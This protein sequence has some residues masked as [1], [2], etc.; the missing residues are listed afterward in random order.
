M[1]EAVPAQLDQLRLRGGGPG[2][3]D[4]IRVR[5]LA[6]LLVRQ[7]DDCRFL[8]RWMPQEDAF[9]LQARDV[10]S[11]ADDHVLDA[12]TDLD[13]TVWMQHCRVTGVEPTVAHHL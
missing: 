1:R 3:Q 7:A 13:V 6:P 12:I 10:L 9:D 2:L 8:H 4:D 11:P 5:G